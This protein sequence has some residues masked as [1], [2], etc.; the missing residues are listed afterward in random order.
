MRRIA[1]SIAAIDL[2]RALNV[3]CISQDIMNPK[4]CHELG[5]SIEAKVPGSV[6]GMGSYVPTIRVFGPCLLDAGLVMI[7]TSGRQ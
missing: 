4:V 1:G 3:C 7:E 2:S 6:V 5:W